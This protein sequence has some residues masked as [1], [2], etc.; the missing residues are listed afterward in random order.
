MIP[1]A[2]DVYFVIPPRAIGLP[3]ADDRVAFAARS[4]H[5]S[6]RLLQRTSRAFVLKVRQ[7]ARLSRV[8]LVLFGTQNF[9]RA[10]SEV[11]CAT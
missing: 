2:Q 9:I 3:A 10:R 8:Q 1:T 4:I 11:P 7:L 5:L 6:F